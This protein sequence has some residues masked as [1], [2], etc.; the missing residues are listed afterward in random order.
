MSFSLPF[1]VLRSAARWWRRAVRTDRR[2]PVTVLLV[3]AGLAMFAFGVGYTLTWREHW[4]E[5]TARALATRND[6]DTLQTLYLRANADFLQGLGTARRAS[7]AWPVARVGSAVAC[8]RRLEASYAR[9]AS[10]AA[11]AEMVLQLRKETAQWEWLLADIAVNARMADGRASVDSAQ[12]LEANRLLA[13]IAAQ[14]GALRD[15]QTKILRSGSDQNSRN[16]EIEG[17]GLALTALVACALLSYAFVAHYRAGLARQRVRLLAA[18]NEDRF[19]KYFDHHALPMLI[20]DV[21]SLDI[22]TANRAAGVQ[23]GHTHDELCALN[24]SSLYAPAD[25]SAFLQELRTVQATGTCSGNAGVCRHLHRD[26]SPLYVELSY[27]F[28]TYAKRDACFITAVDVTARKNAEFALTLRSR[29]LA[30]IGNGVLISRATE[31]GHV[32]EY[33]NP[34]FEKITGYT[35]AQVLGHDYARLSQD[36]VNRKLFKQIH[37]ALANRRETNTLLQSRRADGTSFWGQL[38]IAQV[39]DERDALT[40]HICVVSDLTELVDSRDRLI[41]LARRD[42]LTGLPNRVT[43]REL[44]E[45]AIEE[46]S[47]FALLFMDLDRFKDINDSLGHG[48]GDRLL[49]EA[50]QRISACL[51]E[52]GVATRYGGDEFVAMLARPYEHGRL[53]MLLERVVRA[54][55]M[56]FQIDDVQLRVEM[57]I[58][59]A[60]YP[61]DGADAETLLKHADLA[62]YH[63]KACGRNNVERFQPT[64][65]HA[66]DRRIALSR[67]LHD[68]LEQNSFEL[69]YQPQVDLRTQRVTGVEALIRWHD[70]AIGTVSPATFIP[71]AEE[72]GLIGAIGEWVLLTA[73][74]QARQWEHALPDLR[75]SVNV[76]PRQLARGDFCDVVARVLASTGL[77]AHRLELEITEGALVAP[78]ALPTLRALSEMGLSI[79]IDDFGTGYSSLSYLRSFHADRLKIDLSFVRGIGTSSADEAIIRAILALADSLGSETVAEGVEQTAQLAFLVDH[80]CA[81]V[82]GYHFSAAL[83]ADEIPACIERLSAQWPSAQPACAPVPLR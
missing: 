66:A 23:Y 65:A 50:A 61:G 81:V 12:L 41:K 11:S 69:A 29:A 32:I 46:E 18:E 54:F 55:D 83:P 34:A 59:L 52:D 68:A 63:A 49:R 7:F 82:Q 62:M 2:L 9:D 47:A 10:N 75:M 44:M 14:L 26:G 24:M 74:T 31:R 30:A 15:A 8:F 60:C 21:D 53:A 4:D 45:Q 43:L 1:D 67:L 73:C 48:A 5:A 56:P 78:G 19:R 13:N 58:G 28:L 76:S 80:G 36:S 57:S 25:M 79:A 3:L 40:Y 38:H 27:H 72:I 39:R 33:V 17:I 42:A 37:D 70:P 77:A 16:I 35:R 6:I 64:L 22:I 20:F 71:L 51:G